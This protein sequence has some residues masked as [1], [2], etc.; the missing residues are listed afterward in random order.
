MKGSRRQT[1]AM[2]EPELLDQASDLWDN[3]RTS[4]ALEL[5]KSAVRKDPSL[6]AI[7]LALAERYRETRHPDQAG[8]W[9]IVFD[10]WVTDIERDRLARLLASSG[11]TERGVVKFLSLAD[12]NIPPEIAD[13]LSG[14]VE[15]YRLKFEIPVEGADLGCFG[16]VLFFLWGSTTLVSLTRLLPETDEPEPMIVKLL[17]AA[18]IVCLTLALALCAANAVRFAAKSQAIMWTIMAL[19]TGALLVP[20][21]VSR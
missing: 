1:P 4:E 20:G 19:L 2:T 3:G 18:W 8:R 14:P 7:R 17:G 5:M 21:W 11:V 13:L 10:G 12:R 16:I 6:L 9:G 15:R